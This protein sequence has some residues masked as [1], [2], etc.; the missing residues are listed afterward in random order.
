MTTPR[1]T[2]HV[3]D[4]FGHVTVFAADGV[5][6]ARILDMGDTVR[7]EHVEGVVYRSW[8]VDE[9]REVGAALIGWAGR[10]RLAARV[11]AHD[12]QEEA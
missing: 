1:P 2:H 10:K 12:N 11:K 3:D 4:Y 5:L 7:V 8:T 6:I 9:A